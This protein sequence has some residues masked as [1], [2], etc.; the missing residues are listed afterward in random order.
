MTYK[1]KNAGTVSRRYFTA[2]SFALL[3]AAIA[4][5][6]YAHKERLT[7][8]EID[9]E[10]NPGFLYI[11]HQ[12]ST[13]EA[14]ETLFKAGVLSKPDLY[15]LKSRAELALYAADNF[16]MTLPDGDPIALEILG[17]EIVGRE[18]FVYQ[19]ADLGFLPEGFDIDCRFMR[20]LDPRQINNVDIKVTETVQSLAF[21][22][23]DSLKSVRL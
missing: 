6:A 18:C 14:E 22:G 19:Q 7:R 4:S 21:R 2:G 23:D 17:A 8:T 16:S 10:D 12:F 15:S 11:T 20:E 5:P 13:H 9:W 3:S 1:S